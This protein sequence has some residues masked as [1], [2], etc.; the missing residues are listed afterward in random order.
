MSGRDPVRAVARF[1]LTV[2]VR[3]RRASGGPWGE[4]V[5]AEFGETRGRWQAVRWAVGGLRT[6]WRERRQRIRQLPRATRI[7]RRAAVAAVLAVVAGLSVA[8]FALT[9]QYMASAEMEPT[10]AVTD[11]WVLDRVSLRISGVHHG[12]VVAY[13]K[14]YA[15]VEQIRR[16]IGLPGDTVECRDGRVHRNGSALDEP[17]LPDG[18]RTECEPTTVPADSLYVLGDNRAIATDSRHE[19]TVAMSSVLGRVIDVW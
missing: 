17:Y 9:P 14:R 6:V 18:A 15:H 8:R 13:R 3:G 1:V 11:R 16:V 4:A 19:G 7:R 10:F 5:L 12:D 2:A